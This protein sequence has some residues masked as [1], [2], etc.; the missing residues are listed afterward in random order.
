MARRYWGTYVVMSTFAD[1]IMCMVTSYA[2]SGASLK[3]NIY[4]E[5]NQP[6]YNVIMHAVLASCCGKNKHK[7]PMSVST[8]SKESQE[9]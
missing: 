2:G 4:K 5:A 9:Q 3:I 8:E 6:L 7:L 1:A